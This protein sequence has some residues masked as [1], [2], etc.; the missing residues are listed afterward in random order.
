MKLFSRNRNVKYPFSRARAYF[1]ALVVVGAMVFSTSL[2][3]SPLNILLLVCYFGFTAIV[4]VVWFEL[5][6]R[7]LYRMQAAELKT[8]K[9]SSV[10]ESQNAT[11]W[12]S[13]VLFFGLIISLISPI[14][15]LLFLE[16]AWWFIGFCSFVTGTSLSEVV[17]YLFAEKS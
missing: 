2:L 11:K 3:T 13:I 5:K 15:L 12:K 14:I 9:Y 6:L 1:N 7:L 4:T 17:L 16:P 8:E 10:E